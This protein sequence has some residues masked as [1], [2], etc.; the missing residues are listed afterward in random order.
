MGREPQ[1]KQT[2]QIDGDDLL[3]RSHLSIHYRRGQLTVADNDSRNGTR[4]N[5]AS[6]QRSPLT[7]GDLLRIGDT[8]LLV[9]WATD[10]GDTALDELWGIAPVMAELR[11]TIALVAAASAT[12]VLLGE[13]GTGKGQSAKAI[14]RMS[15]RRGAFVAINCAAIPEALAES[16][17]FGH[18]AGA[19]TG[20]SRDEPGWFRAA[21]RG[22]L[23]IDEIGDMP[24]ALQP[25]LLH[26]IEDGAITPVG[27]T[28]PEPID[29]R[30][31]AA[32]SVDLHDAVA[33]KRFRG[34]LYARLAE[35]VIRVPALCDR[36]EDVL[37]LLSHF[38]GDDAAPIDPDL[39]ERLLLYPWPFNVRELKNVATELGI[40]GVNRDMLTDDLIA[41][42][43]DDPVETSGIEPEP[44]A[45]FTRENVAEALERGRGVVSA[46]ARDLGCSRRHLYRLMERHGLDAKDFRQA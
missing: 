3:S 31:V 30:L 14:H 15:G 27:A 35:L 22:T 43:L 16:M 34:D 18:K 38:L 11:N 26:A 32:T 9:R 19:F 13:S 7:D 29:V 24:A 12:V 25:K 41:W 46:V 20:A 39:A 40:R 5:G 33:D 44:A 45:D 37:L 8:M 42:R 23:F 6:V 28:R 1:A 4:L 10:D 36:R 2:L 17:L 21:H